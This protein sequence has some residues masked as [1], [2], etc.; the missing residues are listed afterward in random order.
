MASEEPERKDR[1]VF[2]DKCNFINA[3]MDHD[4]NESGPIYSAFQYPR[5][6]VSTN[7]LSN[8]LKTNQQIFLKGNKEVNDFK[9]PQIDD[10]RK[11][12]RKN[13][14]GYCNNS[15]DPGGIKDSKDSFY[16]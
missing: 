7:Y 14:K 12:S 5:T 4:L 3:E 9:N 16:Q 11:T 13:V 15:F 10:F 6:D 1:L 8:H 2:F